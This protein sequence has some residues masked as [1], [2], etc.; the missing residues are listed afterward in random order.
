VEKTIDV[1][2]VGQCYGNRPEIIRKLELE[3]F[4]IEAFGYGWPNG[5]LSV[6]EMVRMYSKSKINL[7]FGG[8]AGHKDTYCLKGRDFE[9]PMSGG[10]YLTEYHTELEGCYELGKEI[11]TYTD[12][13]DL[14]A[15]LRYLLANPKEAED[16]RKRGTQRAL[17]EHT[18]EMRF[19]QIFSLMG[20]I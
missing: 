14:V 9:I 16:I 5:A 6:E 3:G 13:E 11:V 20:L 10:L 8:V 19:E 4:K 12:L 18:W 15:K 17:R 1:S 2:F 7:G